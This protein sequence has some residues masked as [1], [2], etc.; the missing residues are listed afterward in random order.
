MEYSNLLYS[1]LQVFEVHPLID[2]SP[3]GHGTAVS[4]AAL[5]KP[6]IRCNY[7]LASRRTIF[8]WM[9]NNWYNFQPRLKKDFR[10]S[11]A[12]ALSI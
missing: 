3:E 1:R 6:G 11:A 4:K 8:N 7:F 10:F 2:Q 5:H 9:Y 12:T